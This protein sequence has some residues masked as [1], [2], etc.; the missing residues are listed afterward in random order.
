M[1][2]PVPEGSCPGGTWGARMV[3]D[4]AT[5]S[6]AR[7]PRPAPGRRHP[8]RLREGDAAGVRALRPGPRR[9]AAPGP[10]HASGPGGPGHPHHRPAAR[11]RLLAGH[12]AARR[13][14][15]R[16]VLPA[17]ALGQ[18]GHAL[19]RLPRR[20][21][22][23]G[24]AA[25]LV[26][27]PPAPHRRPPHRPR[28]AGGP[29]RGG[30]A[31][32]A[33]PA[34]RHARVLPPLLPALRPR[35]RLLG[36][37]LAPLPALGGLPLPPPAP[38]RRL[39]APLPRA[40]PLR[41]GAGPLHL[42]RELPRPAAAARRRRHGRHAE[43]GPAAHRAAVPARPAAR[44]AG[45]PA[46]GRGPRGRPGGRRGGAA[47][48]RLG[49]FAAPPPR[50]GGGLAA[51]AQGRG[52]PRAGRGA[53]HPR[54]GPGEA[55]G[56]GRRLPQREELRPGLQ[57]LDRPHPGRLPAARRPASGAWPAPGRW[58]P[59]SA[60]AAWRRRPPGPRCGPRPPRTSAR[61]RSRS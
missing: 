32:R 48:R 52:P 6:S 50:A 19:P 20:G 55:G 36:H 28:G 35:L 53:A 43:A 27:P 26:P 40:G 5:D 46:P 57:G 22:P 2:P 12:A 7:R 15:P 8:H 59:T 54:P 45:A 34:R 17:A 38:R 58:A 33:P 42:R 49:P 25:P 61:T 56:P 1:P 37:R 3:A 31:H 30:D 60:R 29:G 39:P 14:G 18:P 24:G 9:G 16:L 11:D 13:R 10:D 41:R 47:G 23:G 21:H 4:R 51:G 44:P